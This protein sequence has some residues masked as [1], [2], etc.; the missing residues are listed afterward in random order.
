MWPATCVILR[1]LMLAAAFMPALSGAQ[2]VMS[3]RFVEGSF[4][5]VNVAKRINVT[6]VGREDVDKLPGEVYA[7]LSRNKRALADV[8]SGSAV[9]V[10]KAEPSVARAVVCAV[11]GGCLNVF[12]GKFKYKRTPAIEVFVI[13]PG[14]VKRISG[15]SASNIS[16]RGALRTDGLAIDAGYAMSIHVSVIA[17]SVS[18]MAKDHSEVWVSGD[19]DRLDAELDNCSSLLMR[20]ASCRKVSVRATNASV[21]TVNAAEAVDVTARGRSEVSCFAPG[22]DTSFDCD[23]FSRVSLRETSE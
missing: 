11:E 4:E 13:C 5:A 9:C 2:A 8:A 7:R 1:L 19:F 15:S 10:V 6:L 18:V 3:I 17:P 21:A 20:A 14:V 12:A 22:A 16:T 23:G